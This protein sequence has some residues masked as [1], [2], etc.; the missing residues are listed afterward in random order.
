MSISKKPASSE[1]ENDRL[2]FA[3]NRLYYV[4]FYAMSAIL[5][6]KGDSY[7]KHSGVRS[8]IT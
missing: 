3:I 5:T 6:A 7:S 8:C 2:S 4:L 1:I